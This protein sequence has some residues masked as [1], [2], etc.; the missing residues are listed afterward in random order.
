M[1]KFL[2]ILTVTIISIDCLAQ[3]AEFGK[4]SGNAQY[5]AY[6]TKSGDQINVGDTLVI[7]KPAGIQRFMYIQQGGEYCAPWISGKKVA[8]TQIHSYGKKKNG[9]TLFVQFKGFGL[10]P[11]FMQYDNAIANGEVINPKSQMT[12][13]DAIAKLKEAKDLLDLNIIN[14]SYYDSLKNILAP[15]IIQNK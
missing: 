8:I 5:D 11:V 3:I 9:Y 12:R 1:R 6:I 15:I 13:E 10:I 2:I 4:I 7:G 14:Q